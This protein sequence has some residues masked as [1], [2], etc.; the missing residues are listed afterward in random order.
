[1][2]INDDATVILK[3]IKQG[4]NQG[5]QV[6]DLGEM[7]DKL[8]QQVQTKGLTQELLISAYSLMGIATTLIQHKTPYYVQILGALVLNTNTIAEMRTGEGKTL[9]ALLPLYANALNG[10]GAHLITDNAYLAERDANEARPV[11]QA[12]NMTVGY[13]SDKVK[14]TGEKQIAYNSDVTYLTGSELGFD[15]LKDNLGDLSHEKVQRGFNYVLIDEADSILLDNAQ[16]PLIISGGDQKVK[17]DYLNA[18]LFV[19]AIKSE[20]NGVKKYVKIEK[21]KHQVI[22]TKDGIKFMK[23]W[24]GEDVFVRQRDTLHYVNNALAANFLYQKGVDYLIKKDEK[25]NI[26]VIELIND[27]TGRIING[28]QYSDGMHQAIEAKEHVLIHLPKQTDASITYQSLFQLYPKV[29]GMTGTAKSDAKEL[30]AI[31]NLKVYQ[32]PTNRPVQR[33]DL[34][35]KYFRYIDDKYKE[36]IKDAK[37]YHAKG[38]P[39]LVGTASVESSE[40]LSQLFT[41]AGLEHTVLNANHPDKE[42]EIVKNAGQRGA[43]TIATNMAGRGTDIKIS[44]E[45]KRLGGLVVLGTEHHESK[46]IDDQL[47]GRAGR[48]GDPGITQ[49]YA[50]LDDEICTKLKD[51][52][53]KH[54]KRRYMDHHE[55]LPGKKMFKLF[56]HIQKQLGL[57]QFENRKSSLIYEATLGREREMIYQQRRVLEQNDGL[58][59]FSRWLSDVIVNWVD[60]QHGVSIE[61]L[62]DLAN[63]DFIPRYSRIEAKISKI[64]INNKMDLEQRLYDVIMDTLMSKRQIMGDQLSDKIT[65]WLLSIIDYYW[66]RELSYLVDLKQMIVYQGYA[67]INPYIEYQRQASESYDAM[68]MKIKRRAVQVITQSELVNLKLTVN[69][70]T[71][72]TYAGRQIAIAR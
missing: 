8:K 11:F 55:M 29:A 10:K 33:I 32:V 14:D 30:D 69:E 36:V 7:S 42:A 60:D 1:M 71:V 35:G 68:C 6:K 38:L 37:Q 9:T 5:I 13:N 47:R 40:K 19:R 4:L 27:H 2:S 39:L 16:N 56:E 58:T 62:V 50:S 31:Y 20:K 25:E 26:D 23:R 41:K 64:G 21:D 28:Q 44:E 12:L 22:L 17:T 57:Q 15:Y 24:Y 52:R 70:R 18:N 53:L 66:K 51:V 67:N 45:I 46:R 48:Q 3:Q 65:N 61:E 59:L 72:Q 49:F 43:I 34:P 54:A 63:S